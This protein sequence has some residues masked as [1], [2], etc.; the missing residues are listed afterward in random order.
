MLACRSRRLPAGNGC[1]T[2]SAE[3]ARL[4]AAIASETGDF[5]AHECYC[6]PAVLPDSVASTSHSCHAR[7]LDVRACT[8][9]M[10]SC[11]H[12]LAHVPARHH[13]RKARKGT[14]KTDFCLFKSQHPKICPPSTLKSMEQYAATLRKESSYGPMELTPCDFVESFKGRTL[15]L[16]G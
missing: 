15:W 7:R 12:A 13:R 1:H 4:A 9:R 10:P 14:N 16:L 11:R 6:W 2:S 3:L 5:E 8:C